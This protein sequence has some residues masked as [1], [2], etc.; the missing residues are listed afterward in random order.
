MFFCQLRLGHDDHRNRGD[1]FLIGREVTA[2]ER[3]V[4]LDNLGKRDAARLLEIFLAGR[5]AQV[6]RLVV[7]NGADYGARIGLHQKLPLAG[8]D[9]CDFADCAVEF[10]L[11]GGLLNILPGPSSHQQQRG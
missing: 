4:A 10:A 1:G 7:K 5:H 9:R 3:A 2:D 11:L 8:I 6:K